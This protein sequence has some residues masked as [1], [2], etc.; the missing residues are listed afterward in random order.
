MGSIGAASLALA[1][2]CLP[3][4]QYIA[5]NSSQCPAGYYAGFSFSGRLRLH[6]NLK[7]KR[8]AFS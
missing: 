2:Q 4:F 6:S 7:A 5:P 8:F 1:E 3:A